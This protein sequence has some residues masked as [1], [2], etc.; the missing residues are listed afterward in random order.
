MSVSCLDMLT[1]QRSNMPHSFLDINDVDARGGRVRRRARDRRDRFISLSEKMT[2]LV[3]RTEY[4]FSDDW[5][6][7]LQRGDVAGRP[8]GKENCTLSPTMGVEGGPLSC[9]VTCRAKERT[10][11]GF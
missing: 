7:G 5:L 11:R 9:T 4:R 6:G 2:G 8:H 1:A 3:P 10:N